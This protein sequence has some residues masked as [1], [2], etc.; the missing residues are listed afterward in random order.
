MHFCVYLFTKELPNDKQIQEIMYPYYEYAVEDEEAVD[1]NSK[2]DLRWDS[3][4]VGGRYSGLLKL[5]CRLNEKDD[6]YRWNFYVDAP[7]AGRLFR[8]QFLEKLLNA[9][10]EDK[11]LM[12]KTVIGFYSFNNIE[13]SFFSYSGIR[14]GYVCVDGCKISDLLNSE[15]LMDHG[16]GFVDD[17]FGKQN[18]RNFWNREDRSFVDNPEYENEL[19]AAFD[20]NKDGYLTILDL[21]N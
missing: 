10:K 3:L 4:D 11:M 1:P 12:F 8:C 17:V 14:D 20:R 19:K 6:A 7:R 5:K 15:E 21:H 18:T 13:D 16:Y 9:A 2:V